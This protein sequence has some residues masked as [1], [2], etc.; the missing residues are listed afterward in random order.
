LRIQDLPSA[1]ERR[2]A[3][4]NAR[5]ESRFRYTKERMRRIADARP[6]FTTEQAEALAAI[7]LSAPSSDEG[8]SPA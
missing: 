7:L 4:E 3:T 5:R 2:D 8:A 1:G 6:R